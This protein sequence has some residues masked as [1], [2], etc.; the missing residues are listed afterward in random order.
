[1]EEVFKQSFNYARIQLFKNYSDR[2]TRGVSTS[3]ME[4]VVPYTPL[5]TQKELETFVATVFNEPLKYTHRLFV[6]DKKKTNF[7]Y[8]TNPTESFINHTLPSDTCEIP[9]EPVN[10]FC[11]Q[12]LRNVF[13][14][15]TKDKH[16]RKHYNN[17]F[18]SMELTRVER[19]IK[20]DNNKIRF[21]MFVQV[22]NRNVNNIYFS[23]STHSTTITFD[24]SKGNFTIVTY[25]Q[26]RKIKKKHFYCNSFNALKQSLPVFYNIKDS[27]VNK[28]SPLYTEYLEAFHIIP[29]QSAVKDILGLNDVICGVTSQLIV[30]HFIKEWMKR[31]SEIKKIKLPDNGERLLKWYYPT[32]KFLKKN[33]RK[34][35]AAVLDRFGIK[36][37]V[38]VKILHEYPSTNIVN[39]VYL[40]RLFGNEYP[41]YIGNINDYFYSDGTASDGEDMSGK[42]TIL[43]LIDRRSTFFNITDTEKENIVHI[44]NDLCASS[45]LG[46]QSRGAVGELIDHF[47][48]IEKLKP[49]YPEVQLNATKWN[50]FNTEHSYLSRLEREIQKGYSIQLIYE[51]PLI[52]EI[53]KP[54]EMT[55]LREPP[56]MYC[57]TTKDKLEYEKMYSNYPVSTIQRIFTPKVLISSQ[58][59]FEE[60]CYMSHCVGGYIDNDYSIIVSLRL[61]EERVTC[62]YAIKDRRCIQSRYFHN[63]NPP[64]Y[65]EKALKQLHD[66]IRMMPVPIGPIDRKRV[67]IVING[68]EVKPEAPIVFPAFEEAPAQVIF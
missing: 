44:L 60:G 41:K 3:Q 67:P 27:H 7:F 40:C 55:E 63:Q 49:Y 15:T 39:L 10:L 32:E 38:T 2:I 59:Y 16:I 62:E 37:K 64:T 12:R 51:N 56:I 50:T 14:E 13:F 28:S 6:K 24:L 58:E 26:G 68:V 48:M 11:T 52:Y 47:R 65:F 33:D 25:E 9:F 18:A 57:P 45:P 8:T 29:F 34:L 22:R 54:I 53:E 5:Q 43:V 1:M 46:L 19:W 35:V 31:F 4:L 30:D 42:S 36:T 61:G 21:K 17:P 66:R 20:R 23:K